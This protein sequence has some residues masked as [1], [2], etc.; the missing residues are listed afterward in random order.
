MCLQQWRRQ[1]TESR[2]ESSA[3]RSDDEITALR[4]M[5]M[6]ERSVAPPS[7]LK[8]TLERPGSSVVLA[9]PSDLKDALER[10]RSSVLVPPSDLKDALERPGSNVVLAPPSDLKDALERPGSNVVLAPPSDLKDALERPGSSVLVP[11]SDLKDAL[12]RPGST[13]LAPPSDLSVCEISSEQA[14]LHWTLA[15]LSH[16]DNQLTGCSHVTSHTYTVCGCCVVLQCF[17]TVGWA[18]GRASGL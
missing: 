13:A 4:V 8:D 17:D 15:H 2:V 12:E 16:T 5:D 14:T 9:P 1:V 3:L 11:P 7:D 6:L 10:P 18:S